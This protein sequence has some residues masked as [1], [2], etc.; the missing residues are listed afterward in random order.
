MTTAHNVADVDRAYV[1][2]LLTNVICGNIVT[3]C[4]AD[5]NI[6]VRRLCRC[7]DLYN[8]FFVNYQ[9]STIYTLSQTSQPLQIKEGS[10]YLFRPNL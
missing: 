1:D 8:A 10:E 7:A 4:L 2:A 6:Y 9:L 3:V 5:G